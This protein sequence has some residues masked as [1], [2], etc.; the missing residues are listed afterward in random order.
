MAKID[1]GKTDL[2]SRIFAGAAGMLRPAGLANKLI[3]AMMIFAVSFTAV[4]VA[5][6]TESVALTAM[7]LVT[8]IYLAFG[9]GIFVLAYKKPE[10]AT[11]EGA[12]ILK[13]DRQQGM[14]DQPIL[15]TDPNVK[16][17]PT[18][19]VPRIQKGKDGAGA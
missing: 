16:A 17:E 5:V 18:R 1:E 3:G 8:F 10:V 14:K 4:A 15:P 7:W 13:W 11:M 19:R 2:P 9:A 12:D 6:R